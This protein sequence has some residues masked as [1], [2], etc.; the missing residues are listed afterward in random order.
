MK[1]SSLYKAIL[2]IIISNVLVATLFFLFHKG[3]HS[4]YHIRAMSPAYQVKELL[5]PQL[6]PQAWIEQWLDL[7]LA[8]PTCIDAINVEQAKQQLLSTSIFSEV[9]VKKVGTALAIDYKLRTPIALLKNFSHT[10][11]DQQGYVIAQ[12]LDLRYL[13]SV[14]TLELY[15]PNDIFHHSTIWNSQ[16]PS[17]YLEIIR[18]ISQAFVPLE[19]VR[20][21]LSKMTQSSLGRREIIVILKEGTTYYTLRCNPYDLTSATQR[22]FRLY[23]KLLQPMNSSCTIDLRIAKIALWKYG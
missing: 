22:F 3:Y 19:V 8:H 21:D 15:V 1:E 6:I 18:Y 17:A 7:S 14:P 5:T 12:P 4:Y 2:L 20:I 11:L 13:P 16:I 23:Q 9:T 10:F